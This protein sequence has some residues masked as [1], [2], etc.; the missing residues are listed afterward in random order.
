M[1]GQPAA[2]DRKVEIV[3]QHER[4]VRARDEVVRVTAEIVVQPLDAEAEIG[5][6]AIFD[7]AAAD[8]PRAGVADLEAD[9]PVT[10]GANPKIRVGVEDRQAGGAVEE[11]VWGGPAGAAADACQ[12]ID[13]VGEGDIALD[14]KEEAARLKIIAAMNAADE[15]GAVRKSER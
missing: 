9:R 12:V 7:T 1:V 14:A 6:H 3:L 2:H 8:E 5:A 13:I 4:L 10:G 11:P 15:L